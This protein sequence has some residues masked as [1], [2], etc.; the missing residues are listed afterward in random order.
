MPQIIVT[1]PAGLGERCKKS[2]KT[3][4][5]NVLIKKRRMGNSRLKY[6]FAMRSNIYFNISMG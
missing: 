5:D 3:Q 6:E 4:D 2:G 1:S